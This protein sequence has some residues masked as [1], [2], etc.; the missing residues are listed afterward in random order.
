SEVSALDL[1]CILF[2]VKIKRMTAGRRRRQTPP[3]RAKIVFSKKEFFV[4]YFGVI[5]KKGDS[6]NIESPSLYKDIRLIT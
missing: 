5:T 3:R 2:Y 6:K 4:M 1:F